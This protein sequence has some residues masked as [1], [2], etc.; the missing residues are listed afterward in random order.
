M[1]TFGRPLRQ[2]PSIAP[3]GM[4]RSS[5]QQISPLASMQKLPGN[6]NPNMPPQ[7][8]DVLKPYQAQAQAPAGAGFGPTP[9]ASQQ[10]QLD[11]MNAMKG[12]VGGQPMPAGISQ[13][14]MPVNAGPLNQAS[15]LASALGAGGA[16]GMKKGGAVKKYAKGGAVSSAPAS[17][18]ARSSASS[19]GDGCAIRGKTKG[20]FV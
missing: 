11:A 6:P 10:S 9:Q 1:A 8:T 18:S 16:M 12:M 3:Q 4:G 5:M 15:G 13:Y 17:K 20:R 14:A 7:P 2:N 19:R